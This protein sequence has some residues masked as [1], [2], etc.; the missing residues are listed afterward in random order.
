[1][2]EGAEGIITERLED[3]S[4]VVERGRYAVVRAPDGG[5]TISRRVYLCETC[6]GHDCGEHAEPL[7]AP[8]WA[9]KMLGSPGR[10]Q[11]AIKLFMK[12]AGDDGGT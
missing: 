12:G 10:M 11:A 2:S 3:G 8:A 1:M 4:E 5:I 6:V 9:M 7:Q